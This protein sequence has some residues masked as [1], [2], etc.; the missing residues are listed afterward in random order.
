MKLNDGSAVETGGDRAADEREEEEDEGKGDDF[1]VGYTALTEALS[2]EAAD[3]VRNWFA[4]ENTPESVEFGFMPPV[5]DKETRT[6]I[7]KIMKENFNGSLITDTVD[8]EEG[9]KSKL[10]FFPLCHSYN[11]LFPQAVLFFPTRHHFILL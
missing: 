6:K 8:D 3:R 5:Q 4:V 7:H 10:D 1:E 9:G 11:S 2:K